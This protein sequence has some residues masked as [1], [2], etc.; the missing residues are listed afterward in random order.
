MNPYLDLAGFKL[1]TLMPSSDVDLVEQVQPGFTAQRIA[2]WSSEINASARKRY[3][4]NT[5]LGNHLPFG[6]IPPALVANGTTPPGIT[7][8]GRPVLGCS[9]IWIQILT[10]GALGTATFAWSADGGITWAPNTPA[11]LL[12]GAG[13][14]FTTAAVY[15][16]GSTGVAAN[17]PGNLPIYSADNV[18]RAETPV[19]EVILSW[20]VS[21]V[22]VDLYMKRGTNP[23]D[24]GIAMLV[25]EKTRALK[26][27]E[28]AA[29][30][31]DGLLDL[32]IS[33]DL[34][35]AVTTGGP[36]GYSEASP[37]VWGDIQACRAMG[38]DY[39]RW[40]S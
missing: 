23:N 8:T 21:V 17:F 36:L 9:R 14:G 37:Y 30:G 5:M 6:Q 39:Q 22:T 20:L 1:R 25:D 40:G 11:A 7:L 35:S 33:E 24:P 12:A 18:Y 3:G 19:P 38:E 13:A 16:L 29:N 26:R 28:D 15:T 10:G 2:N 32:P 4:N 31:K 34:D 27:L